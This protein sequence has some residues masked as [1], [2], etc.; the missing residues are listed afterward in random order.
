M[1]LE[2]PLPS[3]QKEGP[4]PLFLAP[5]VAPAIATVGRFDFP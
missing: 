4:I 2:S 3:I 5:I 1:L